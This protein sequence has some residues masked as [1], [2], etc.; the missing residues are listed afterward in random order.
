[1]AL[2]LHP[3]TRHCVRRA[4][5]RD[6]CLDVL[7]DHGHLTLHEL[8]GL[9]GTSPSRADGILYGGTEDHTIDL[10]LVPLG[11]V[12]EVLSVIGLEFEL[13]ELGVDQARALR[14]ARASRRRL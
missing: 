14:V 3:T 2:M 9:V 6:L 10:A 7:L 1:M 12:R 4:P 5:K 8:A 13:T 11:L